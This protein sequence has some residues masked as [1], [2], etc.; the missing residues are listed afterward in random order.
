MHRGGIGLGLVKRILQHHPEY[1][2]FATCRKPNVASDLVALGQTY[3]ADRLIV[4]ALDTTQR[5]EYDSVLS[6]LRA[7]GVTALDVL[8]AN[9]GI[10]SSNRPD[11]PLDSTGEDMLNVYNT[12]VVGSV[13]T[14]QAFHNLVCAGESKIVMVVSSV[15]GSIERVTGMGALTSYRASK[16]ALNMVAM[17]YAENEALR[18]VGGKV[19][20][21]HPGKVLVFLRSYN[22]NQGIFLYLHT[23]F[24]FRLGAD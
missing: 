17:T 16:A 2:V 14:M 24:T 5:A 18:A 11:F 15:L 23:I 21:L 1:R 20:A 9:A 7:A 13:L 4:A 6:T 8:I 19:I 12:N 3:G 10:A 22:V